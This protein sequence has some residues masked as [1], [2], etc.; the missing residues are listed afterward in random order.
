MLLLSA[1]YSRLLANMITTKTNETSKFVHSQQGAWP[2]SRMPY[3]CVPIF[4]VGGI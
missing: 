4:I 3:V 1:L 2:M